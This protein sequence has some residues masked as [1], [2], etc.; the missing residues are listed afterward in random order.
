MDDKETTDF[1]RNVVAAIVGIILIVILVFA[2][3]WTGDQIREKFSKPKPEPVIVS[4]QIPSDSLLTDKVK[5]TVT[6]SAIP[7]TGPNDWLY[8][9]VGI[10]FISGLGIKFVLK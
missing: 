1:G 8:A 5:K 4:Q 7:E 3:K 10:M 2:A 6:Y 9:V